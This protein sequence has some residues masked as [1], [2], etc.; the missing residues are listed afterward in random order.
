MYKKYE[1][2]IGDRRHFKKPNFAPL[3][4]RGH[5]AGCWIETK[6]VKGQSSP[7]DGGELEERLHVLGY[8][9]PRGRQTAVH[10]DPL[11]RLEP[12]VARYK[13]LQTTTDAQF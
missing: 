2:G 3:V 13:A 9:F 5:H 10:P 6:L 7:G 11:L 4:L 12:Q 8:R 1:E